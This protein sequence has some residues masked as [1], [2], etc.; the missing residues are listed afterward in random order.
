MVS[1]YGRKFDGIDCTM[2]K[3]GTDQVGLRLKRTG[4]S[5]KATVTTGKDPA[6]EANVPHAF[7]EAHNSM[8]WR[9]RLKY[10]CMGG[11]R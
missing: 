5:Y 3:V 8:S 2:Y 1:G 10:L 7:K 4:S 11:I 6:S 9:R